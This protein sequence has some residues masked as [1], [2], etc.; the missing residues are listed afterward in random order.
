M[1]RY[2][3]EY[4]IKMQAFLT[5]KDGEA[6]LGKISKFNWQHNGHLEKYGD[7]LRINKIELIEEILHE[8]CEEQCY[9]DAYVPADVVSVHIEKE[10]PK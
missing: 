5:V 2:R 9:S 4:T 7:N 3:M 8:P 6:V 1:R 10:E